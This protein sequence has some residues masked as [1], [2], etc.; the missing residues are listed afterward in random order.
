[1]TDIRVLTNESN[2]ICITYNNDM[3]W[4]S[5]KSC[6]AY[7]KG[8]KLVHLGDDYNFSRTTSKHIN[9]FI[10]EFPGVYL[11]ATGISGLGRYTDQEGRIYL[12]RLSQADRK[13]VL[14]TYYAHQENQNSERTS[15]ND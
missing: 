9:Q 2:R 14:D 7:F 4:V 10:G 5:Y 11:E 1:M 8:P 6:I 13:T 12:A 15:D 3:I